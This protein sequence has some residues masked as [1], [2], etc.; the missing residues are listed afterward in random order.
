MFSRDPLMHNAHS[1][2]LATQPRVQRNLERELAARSKMRVAWVEH[3]S[4]TQP[5]AALLRQVIRFW[6]VDRI[7]RAAREG[8]KAY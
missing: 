1:S 7:V 3:H 2:E 8:F 5:C 6:H 4:T